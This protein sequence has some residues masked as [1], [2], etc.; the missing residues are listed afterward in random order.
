MQFH[1]ISKIR[2]LWEDIK[3]DVKLLTRN[4]KFKFDEDFQKRLWGLCIS[5][6]QRAAQL[7]AFKNG[8]SKKIACPSHF[9]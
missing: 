7:L 1:E 6:P 4:P 3:S 9:S 8:G 2:V 5:V